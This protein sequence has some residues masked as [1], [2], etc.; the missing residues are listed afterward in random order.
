MKIVNEHNKDGVLFKTEGEPSFLSAMVG[1]KTENIIGL[2]GEFK[3]GLSIG[4]TAG[5]G[6]EVELSFTKE[7]IEGGYALYVGGSEHVKS[8]VDN[9]LATRLSKLVA[10]N[11]EILNAVYSK[12]ESSITAIIEESE[13]VNAKLEETKRSIESVLNEELLIENIQQKIQKSDSIYKTAL[14]NIEQQKQQIDTDILAIESSI[15]NIVTYDTKIDANIK[16]IEKKISEMNSLKETFE[17]KVEDILKI[18]EDVK[19]WRME[20]FTLIEEG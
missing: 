8:N 1:Y 15:Q 17:N 12:T 10:E 4:V 2:S 16:N 3:S 20:G 19:S 18:E 7:K 9:I 13:V 11:E 6:V 14:K 5:V